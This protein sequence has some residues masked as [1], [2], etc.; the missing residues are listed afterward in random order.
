MG[1][2]KAGAEMERRKVSVIATTVEN[3]K[4]QL[5]LQR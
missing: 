2:K 4:R 3:I 1:V 5:L